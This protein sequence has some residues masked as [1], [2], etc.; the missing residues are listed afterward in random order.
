M[1]TAYFAGGCYWGVE[2]VFQ[3]I[4]GVIGTAVGYMG[5]TKDNPTYQEV[6]SDKTGHAETVCIEFDESV[7]SYHYLLDVFFSNHNPTE[8]M[9]Q[10]PDTGSQ[11]RSA[12]F[13]TSS[14]QKEESLRYIEDLR[15]KG[16]YEEPIVTEVLQAGIFWPAEEYHQSY[17]LKMGRRYGQGIL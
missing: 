11:Y 5:G 9:K 13:Y 2:A 3:Q 8:Y 17:Y 16:K 1:R 7:I 12:I 6:C 15:L 4:P 14:D 10:G